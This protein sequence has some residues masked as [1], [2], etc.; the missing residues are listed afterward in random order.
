M[1]SRLPGGLTLSQVLAVL[2][3]GLLLTA[4]FPKFS[5][6][7]LLLIAL[8]PLF[9]A[10]RGLS[11]RN[12]FLLGFING[13]TNNLTLF[14][15]IVYVTHVYGHLPL[16]LGFAIL[17]LLAAYLSL[18]RGFWAWGVSWGQ[19][20]GLNL[21]W[22]APA[23]WVA[24]EFVQACLFTG[25]PW[26]LLG[27]ALYDCRLLVQLADL[28]GV[29]GLSFV[30]VLVNQ[31]IFCLLLTFGEAE[32]RQRLQA[33]IL[34]LIITGGTIAYG[35]FRVQNIQ[36]RA[37]QSPQLPVAV[38]Q[39]NIEQGQK[40]NPEFQ[41]ATIDIYAE[42][43]RQISRAQ[44]HLVIWPET[45][46]PF[47]F[48]RE[49]QMS[50]QVENIA[51]QAQSYLLFGSP[52]FEFQESGEQKFYNRAY[53]LSPQGKVTGSYDKA[54]LVPYG[55]YVPLRRYFFFVG[56]MVPMVGDF[57]SGPPGVVLSTP[58]VDVG[59]LICFESI[60]P[61]LSRA[62]AQNG[63][64]LL[65]NITNDAWFGTTSAPYQ[66]LSMAV[67]RAVENRLS[68]ARA[69]NTGFSA[70]IHPDGRII[71]RS[72]LFVATAE[73]ATLPLGPGNSF[74]SR[75]GNIFAYLCLGLVGL[76]LLAGGWRRNYQDFHCQGKNVR[77]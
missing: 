1:I 35:H 20:R 19:R 49:P 32:R 12:A 69:A 2:L 38:V 31:A 47:F 53:L 14:Y 48:L 4:A 6:T 60:F 51:Q 59:T 3:S 43:T 13:L 8:V 65:V 44:P 15:W 58:K 24:L 29:Y 54:H 7:Y 21:L 30:I 72:E 61:E 28:T 64:N 70:F 62:M 9:W 68:L 50:R 71:W 26:E 46:A 36:R 18:Y 25:F 42:L 52:A 55:E 39:G 23:L 37:A 67:L 16:I 57:A 74:Y 33:L 45:A 11:G 5:Q 41:Q 27:Y 22:W 56:K 17:L 75:F 34:T 66:H 76:G 63:A 77:G 73:S 10:L 40:W